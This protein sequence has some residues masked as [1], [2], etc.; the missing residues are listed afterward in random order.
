MDVKPPDA[1]SNDTIP[2]E[3]EKWD[4]EH[5][6]RVREI[7]LKIRAQDLAEKEHYAKRE[8]ARRAVWFNPL[9]VAI[10]AAAAAAAGNA[11]IAYTNGRNQRI[12]EAEKSEQ[13][14]ILE[15]IK[16]GNPDSAAANLRF[17]IDTGLVA[18]E[19]VVSKVD[20]YLKTRRDGT[21]A[22]LP[23]SASPFGGITG[24]DDAIPLTALSAESPILNAAKSVGQLRISS[25]GKPYAACTGFLVGVDLVVTANQCVQANLNSE[26]IFVLGTPSREATFS[27]IQ[28]A[29]AK[30]S[31]TS[32]SEGL[33]LLK[34]SGS[35]GQTYGYL[36]IESRDLSVGDPLSIV[37]FRQNSTKLA[38]PHS[39][40]CKI[41]SVKTYSIR[42]GCDTGSGSG[43]APIL[44]R[45]TNAVVGVHVL[46]TESGEGEAV[47][48]RG[49]TELVAKHR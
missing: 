19:N 7:D 23:T 12:L 20:A 4:A 30:F 41:I 45:G 16:T 8:D 21:G 25:N 13:T 39:P 14:R 37:L 35:P 10:L 49:L 38:V 36:K 33:T 9:A 24:F 27:V 3:R 1:S 44:D 18:N 6:Q 22:A 26:I 34:V 29:L 17:L 32:D 31:E 5:L 11:F 40:E 48:A 47:N 28:P 42:H 15:M 46:R 43:G 2:F